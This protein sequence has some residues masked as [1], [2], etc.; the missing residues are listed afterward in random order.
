VRAEVDNILRVMA[1]NMAE[2]RAVRPPAGIPATV[3]IAA[4]KYERSENPPPAQI[5]AG[6]LRLQIKHE[7]EWA[8]AS[9]DGLMVVERN[10]SHY[11]HRDD[12]ALIVQLIR[13]ALAAASYSK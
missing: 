10:L 9:P 11:V 6:L 5:A 2:A 12:P 1:N 7:Q 3:L 4:G 13:H 8:L